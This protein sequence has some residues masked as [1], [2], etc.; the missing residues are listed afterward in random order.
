ML[1]TTRLM[2]MLMAGASLSGTLAFGADP[3][4]MNLVM[5]DAKII[6]GANLTNI[7][8]SPI[9]Q[10]LM[11][12]VGAIAQSPDFAKLGFNPLLDVS[13]VLA[14]SPGNSA[15]ISGIIMA[16]GTFPVDK[17]AAALGGQKNTQIQSY[18][19]ATL[20]V[21]GT[22]T[23][24]VAHALAFIGNSLVVVGDL[25]SVKAAI[26]RQTNPTAIDSAL[27]VKIN[28]LSSSEDE[29]LVS[30]VPVS[31]LI[32]S[33][34]AQQA[35]G[36]TGPAAQVLPLL[37]SIQSLNGGIKFGDTISIA[38]QAVTSDPKNAAALQAVVKLGIAL[39]SSLNTAN[40]P[41]FAALLQILQS[42]QANVDGSA[43]NL[44]LSIP[45]SQVESFI[46][47]IP[48]APAA[49]GVA[50]AVHRLDRRGPEPKDR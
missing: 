24:N 35:G 36:A 5:P 37:K 6:A 46:N 8:I 48:K 14:A 33:N 7:R 23:A 47:S 13:E 3:N 31:S 15:A 29:W 44:A 12:K 19:G 10:F 30:T 1:Q 45:E 18:G 27:A 16:T 50:P 21:N 39:A 34:A 4:L 17:I 22:D 38:G 41:Q 9:G 11:S 20:I 25:A 42:L 43:V 26:D 28:Q 2:A 40:N 32:P 49:A